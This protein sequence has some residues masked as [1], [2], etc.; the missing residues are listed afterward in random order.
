MGKCLNEKMGKCLNE[1][2]GK[3]LDGKMGKEG[4]TLNYRKEHIV[5]SKTLVERMG[6]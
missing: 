6:I 5:H 3:C 4:D 1:E 2:M